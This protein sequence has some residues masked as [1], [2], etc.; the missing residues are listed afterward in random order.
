MQAQQFNVCCEASS[1]VTDRMQGLWRLACRIQSSSVH[2]S[3]RADS[4][5]N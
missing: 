5:H 2:D 3:E 1:R 4:Q